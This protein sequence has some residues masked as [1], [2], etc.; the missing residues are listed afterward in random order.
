MKS[1]VTS[2]VHKA[3]LLLALFSVAS[4]AAADTQTPP[5]QRTQVPGYYRMVLGNIEVTAFDDGYVMLDP[6]VLTGASDET[7]HS[8]LARQFMSAAD[9]MRTWINGYLVHTG[10]KLVLIDTGA[11][12]CFGPTA[13]DLKTNLRKAG[14]TPAQIDV[15]LLTHLHGDHACGLLN[16]EGK[17]AFTNAALRV[18]DAEAAYWLSDQVAAKAPDSM[19]TM[20]AMA[21][22]AVAPY[23]VAG[24]FSTF[25]A[26]AQLLPAIKSLATVGHTPGHTSYLIGTG[27]HKLLVLGDIIHNFAV[28]FPRPEVAVTFDTNSQ[29]A[30][31]TRKRQFAKAAEKGWWLAGAHL[32]FP[33]IGHIRATDSGYAWVPIRYRLIQADE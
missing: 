29:K 24:R 12:Q 18:S 7:I 21:R 10:R 22:R 27:E 8:L 20:F 16:R 9:G 15:V 25:T 3:L 11:G 33:G 5:Q 28:Q 30:I 13:G 6:S 26:G 23:K 2:V 31:A 14:Y 17:A 4:I 32:P 1:P 19:Q